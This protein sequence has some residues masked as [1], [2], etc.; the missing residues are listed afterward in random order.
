MLQKTLLIFLAPRCLFIKLN[1]QIFKQ[2]KFFDEKKIMFYN[3]IKA[4]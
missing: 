1:L 4:I 3:K 2:A